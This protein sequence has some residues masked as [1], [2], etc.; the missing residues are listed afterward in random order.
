MGKAGFPGPGC[1]PRTI[2]LRPV[3]I[4]KT[5]N[6]HLGWPTYAAAVVGVIG[7]ILWVAGNKAGKKA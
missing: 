5:E 2:P 7:I 1:I 4:N 3:E 6:K